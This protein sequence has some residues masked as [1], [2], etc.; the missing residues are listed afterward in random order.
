MEDIESKNTNNGG[1]AMKTKGQPTTMVHGVLFTPRG[2]A[3]ALMDEQELSAIAHAVFELTEIAETDSRRDMAEL[4]R[5]ERILKMQNS[6]IAI[7]S[8][9]MLFGVLFTLLAV[10]FFRGL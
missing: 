6:G 9:G 7:S 3:D 1:N 5:R 8:V 10:W 4:E 2:D